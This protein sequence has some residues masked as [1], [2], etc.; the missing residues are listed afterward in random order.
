MSSDLPSAA[1][2]GDEYVV[3][4]PNT[5]ETYRTLYDAATDQAASKSDGL[6]VLPKLMTYVQVF[7]ED[8]SSS[9]DS[10]IQSSALGFE[11]TH[12]SQLRWCVR[13]AMVNASI[14]DDN[15]Y[16]TP[17]SPLGTEHIFSLLA[18]NKFVDYQVLLDSVDADASLHNAYAQSQF[19]AQTDST[20]AKT[21]ASLADQESPYAELGLTPL[22]FF[23]SE[24]SKID[25]LYWSFLKALLLKV[26]GSDFN[27][28]VILNVF[29]SESKSSRATANLETLSEYFVRCTDRYA[30]DSSR[31]VVNR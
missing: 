21:S 30:D 6:L 29:N 26:S 3:L 7:E 24:E 31:L 27:D 2:V 25:R 19:W 13:V 23:G 14:E 5:L 22:H 15:G 18:D 4:P 1:A 10:S 28:F 12:R 16:A 17:T 20:G 8:V 11:T 9:E